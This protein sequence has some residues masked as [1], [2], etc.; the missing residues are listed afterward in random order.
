MINIK[1]AVHPLIQSRTVVPSY[2]GFNRGVET[3]V[4]ALCHVRDA[5][6][7]VRG[8]DQ[9]SVTL[10]NFTSSVVLDQVAARVA[11]KFFETLDVRTPFLV[12]FSEDSLAD[13]MKRPEFSNLPA[14]YVMSSDAF[15]RD[16][17]EVDSSEVDALQLGV[18]LRVYALTSGSQHL[19]ALASISTAR[20]K[21]QL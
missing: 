20:A 14:T 6:V 2:G 3:P 1:L 9:V 19:E 10:T 8:G 7:S 11:A 5:S 15:K 16:V 21:Y 18:P 4:V 12:V 17:E 13:V